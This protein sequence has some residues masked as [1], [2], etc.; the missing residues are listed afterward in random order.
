MGSKR[1]GMCEVQFRF[2]GSPNDADFCADWPGMQKP[3]TAVPKRGWEYAEVFSRPSLDP[4]KMMI[5]VP[6]SIRIH[7]VYRYTDYSQLNLSTPG[8]GTQW[9]VNQTLLS[10]IGRMAQGQQLGPS[11]MQSLIGTALPTLSAPD[12]ASILHTMNNP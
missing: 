5:P 10:F 7:Q 9:N 8:S 2:A 4:A 1:A 3:S 6:V 12:L 11:D